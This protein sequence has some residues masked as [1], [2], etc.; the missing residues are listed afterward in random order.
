MTREYQ[1]VYRRHHAN[2]SL[3]YT[4]R[5]D[6]EQRKAALDIFFAESGATLRDSRAYRRTLYRFL[7]CDA[8][9]CAS[10]AFNDGDI[11]GCEEL[12]ELAHELCSRIWFSAPSI[13]L[14]GKRI[15]GVRASR[16]LRTV[17]SQLQ[18][19]KQGLA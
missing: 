19:Q 2:M 7:G 11:A 4:R 10:A 12:R 17:L 15:L 6:L 9:R 8:M 13:A 18:G 14:T 1:A 16:H 3:Q 5:R